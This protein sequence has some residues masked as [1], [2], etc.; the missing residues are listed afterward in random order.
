MIKNAELM[1][2]QSV[3]SSL[4]AA[5]IAAVFLKPSG[6]VVMTGAKAAREGTGFMI[7][8]GMAKAAVH[9]LTKSLASKSGGLPADSCVVCILPVTLDTPGNRAN[10]PGADT[11]TWTPLSAVS[12]KLFEWAEGQ[13]RPASGSLVDV[14]TEAGITTFHQ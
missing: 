7:G 14:T 13:G 12:T 4:I 9:Q 6:L 2:D 11:A 10:M 8:Y 1:W 5:R 3:K